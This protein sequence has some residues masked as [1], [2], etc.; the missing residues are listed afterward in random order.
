VVGCHYLHYISCRY[1]TLPFPAVPHT[2][3]PHL[4]PIPVCCYYRFCAAFTL[5]TPFCI[6]RFA[7]AYLSTSVFSLV[8]GSV[9]AHVYRNTTRLR[10]RSH[11]TVAR[12]WRCSTVT[13]ATLPFAHRA[14]YVCPYAVTATFAAR[15]RFTVCT[16]RS[17]R[18][19]SLRL[20]LQFIIQTYISPL[21]CPCS[22][23]GAPRRHI[24]FIPLG[25]YTRLFRTRLLPI[26]RHVFFC[27][28]R[29]VLRLPF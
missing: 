29:T 28:C 6:L 18:P 10:L 7:F 26:A 25:C 21:V 20:H 2:P 27:R 19:F 3:A 24:R 8:C 1:P 15:L 14:A 23:T 12:V 22:F 13:C 4:L 5:Y 9:A 11:C 17:L 16:P